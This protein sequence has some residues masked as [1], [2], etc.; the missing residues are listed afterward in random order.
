[1]QSKESRISMRRDQDVVT[2]TETRLVEI[3]SPKR[4]HNSEYNTLPL[5][6]SK[7]AKLD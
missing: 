4:K 7:C 5:V 6:Y 3:T 1:M 2:V